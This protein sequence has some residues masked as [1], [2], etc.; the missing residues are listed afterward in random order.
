MGK[1]ISIIGNKGGTGK[2]TLSHMVAHG[3]GLFGK[4]AAAILTDTYRDKLSRIGRTY[5]PF[6][7]RRP[8]NLLRVAEGMASVR[9]WFGIIDGGGNRPEMDERLA[10]MSD[11]V[12]LPF[13]ESHEDIRTLIRD[14]ERFPAAWAVPSQWPTN[15]WAEAAAQ[16]SVNQLLGP[17]SHR[18]LAPVYAW[19]RANC[20]SRTRWRSPCRRRSTMPA[21]RSRC[22]RWSCWASKSPTTAGSTCATA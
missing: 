1:I 20:C 10:A 5:L 13:R 11:L 21:A 9:A 12:I 14:L 6:D 22:R 15:R 16:R 2:T 19:A 7:A 3:L 17:W 8:E 4:H 18:I